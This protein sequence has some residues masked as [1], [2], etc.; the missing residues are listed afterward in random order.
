MVVV[1]HGGGGDV[2]G[3]G[4]GGNGTWLRW[5]LVEGRGGGAT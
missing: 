2:V 4:G 3:V 1:V 5:Y